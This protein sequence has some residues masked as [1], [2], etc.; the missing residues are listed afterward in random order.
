MGIAFQVIMSTGMTRIS[1]DHKGSLSAVE[2]SLLAVLE[3]PGSKP[4]I[5]KDSRLRFLLCKIVYQY[6]FFDVN[7]ENLRNL[8]E[9]N[10]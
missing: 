5:S 8:E 3:V 10:R 7:T 4:D 2:R 6:K 1:V 9:R